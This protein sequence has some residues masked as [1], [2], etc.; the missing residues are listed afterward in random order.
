[1]IIFLISF[2]IQ[3]IYYLAVYARIIFIRKQ[4]PKN[5]CSQPLTVIISAR[6]EE[7]N[8]RKFIPLIMSQ[9]YDK[10]EVIIID[11]NSDDSSLKMLNN[12]SENY[13]NLK[14]LTAEKNTSGKGNKKKSLTKAISKAENEILVFT[15]AD[16]R[17]V[18]NKWLQNIASAYS[19][20]TEIVLAYGA[21]EKQKGLLNK[22]IRYETL[23][24]ALQYLSF[25]YIGLP[26]MA[27]G[28]NLSYKKSVFVKNKGFNSHKNILYGDD[29]LFINEVATKKNTKITTESSSKTVS[30]PKQTFREYIQQK[31]RHLAAGFN[32][33]T[34]NKII[35]G[36]EIL[37]R[38]LFYLIFLY[39]IVTDYQTKVVLTVFFIRAMMICCVI[40]FFAMKIKEQNNLFFIPIFDLLIPLI[41]L[42]IVITR[43][44]KKDI[45]WK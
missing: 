20:N 41:N 30:V 3:T 22:L 18:S 21:Y 17:P 15:D 1:M 31:K 6:N 28:R 14:V 43:Y 26:F 29:D 24:N 40:K 13:E 37:S 27:A 35:I 42:Y 16:C 9:D 12:L 7:N 38:F 44:F 5:K 33:K 4:K 45:V 36:T 39:F 19:E 23:Y 34:K 25:A 2:F 32:Y 11:D 10:F 8:L